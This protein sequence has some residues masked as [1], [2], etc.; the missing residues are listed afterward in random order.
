MRV[1]R[2]LAMLEPWAPISQR[3]RRIYPTP[4]GVNFKLRHYLE[5]DLIDAFGADRY[6][7]V[8]VAREALTDETPI[9][10][11]RIH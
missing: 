3:L 10:P 2:V 1:P 5:I 11:T 4:F 9:R 7:R 8:L 6:T